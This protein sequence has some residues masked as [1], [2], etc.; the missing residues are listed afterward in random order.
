MTD[1]AEA[2]VL[3]P[4]ATAPAHVTRHALRAAERWLQREGPCGE[5]AAALR[6]TAANAGSASLPE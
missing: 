2:S 5:F 3:S 6:R 4:E 1:G